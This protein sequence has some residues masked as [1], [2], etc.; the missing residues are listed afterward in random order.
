MLLKCYV[1][2]DV[3][4]KLNGDDWRSKSPSLSHFDDYALYA[5]TTNE[6]ADLIRTASTFAKNQTTRAPL[7]ASILYTSAK[8]SL[9]SRVLCS[10]IT[11]RSPVRSL[12]STWTPWCSNRPRQ[13]FLYCRCFFNCMHLHKYDDRDG[14]RAWK[15]QSEVCQRQIIWDAQIYFSDFDPVQRETLLIGT[16]AD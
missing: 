10:S 14:K 1:A 5:A 2:C 3:V 12:N 8:M 16:A 4:K 15:A 6:L 9:R 7:H 11:L 13:A